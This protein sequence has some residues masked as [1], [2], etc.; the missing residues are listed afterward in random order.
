MNQD[1]ATPAVEERPKVVSINGDPIVAPEFVPDEQCVQSAEIISDLAAR[2]EITGIIYF[3]TYREGTVSWG[4][5]G[6]INLPRSLGTMQIAA[7]HLIQNN[8]DD[9]GNAPSVV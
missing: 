2:G 5:G 9:E 7:V 6:A 1:N 4:E 3:V 8:T